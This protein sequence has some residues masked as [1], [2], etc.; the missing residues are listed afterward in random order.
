MSP[1]CYVVTTEVTPKRTE[2]LNVE[3]PK[4]GKGNL[5]WGLRALQQNQLV[6]NCK[7]DKKIPPIHSEELN[8]MEQMVSKQIIFRKIVDGM[9]SVGFKTGVGI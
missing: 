7:R 5:T 4:V 6:P 1:Q 3:L 9:D 8:L 2:L